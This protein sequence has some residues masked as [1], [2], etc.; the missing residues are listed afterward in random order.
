[1]PIRGDRTVEETADALYKWL[2]ENEGEL[3]KR[4]QSAIHNDWSWGKFRESYLQKYP[5]DAWALGAVQPRLTA[6]FEDLIRQAKSEATKHVLFEVGTPVFLASV[7]VAWRLSR[8]V[9]VAPVKYVRDYST[10]ATKN[11]SGTFKSE[12]EARNLVRQKIGKNPVEVEPGKWRSQDGKWQYR[13]KPADL[14]DRHIHLE[15]LNPETGEVIQNLHL[16]W[17]E[18]GGR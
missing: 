3:D 1:L 7:A 8:G 4:A 14:A 18:G 16:R 9:S 6:G 13:A 12:G 11:W 15:E 5:E 17:P 10:R 2:S